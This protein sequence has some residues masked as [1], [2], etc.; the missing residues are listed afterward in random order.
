[1]ASVDTLLCFAGPEAEPNSIG[2]N[3]VNRARKAGLTDDQIRDM[4]EKE[5]L[6]VGDK[7]KEALLLT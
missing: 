4:I 7:A 6:T 1:M 3:A 5:G 2:L